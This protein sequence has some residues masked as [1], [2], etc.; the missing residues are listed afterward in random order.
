[1]MDDTQAR[2]KARLNRIADDLS[3]EQVKDIE[4]LLASLKVLADEHPTW[5]SIMARHAI[6]T[7]GDAIDEDMP[8]ARSVIEGYILPDE[9]GKSY[10]N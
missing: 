3:R 10:T 4:N 2:L 7:A 5:A 6:R 8:E 9:S 1:M